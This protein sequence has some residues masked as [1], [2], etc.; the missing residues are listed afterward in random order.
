MAIKVYMM[1]IGASEI[2]FAIMAK[3]TIFAEMAA[4]AMI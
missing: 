2:T 1:A 3:M 4:M